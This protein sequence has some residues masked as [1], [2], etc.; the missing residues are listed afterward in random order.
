MPLPTPYA[1]WFEAVVG[2][3][4]PEEASATCDDCPM[5]AA[6]GFRP[7]T[8]CCTY[9]PPMANFQM[10]RA[11][12]AGGTAASAVRRRQPHAR[13]S[14]LG[15]LP[16][17]AEERLYE[18]H[19]EAFGRTQAVTCPFLKDGGCAVWAFRDVTCATWFCQHDAGAAGKA[20][21]DCA[22]DL[23]GLAEGLLAAHLSGW[24]LDEAAAEAERIS[25][26]EIR[27]LPGGD[28]LEV[29]ERALREAWT[30]SRAA[31]QSHG[32]DSEGLP[33]PGRDRGW[34]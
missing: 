27:A 8:K 25:W 33:A 18:D 5:C 24:P 19:H 11:L 3:P 21:W 17:R 9:I 23:L 2:A 16:T 26:T 30:L 32:R 12:R 4:P 28:A 29:H 1:G 31:S 20:M 10:A 14:P 6:R 22:A 15:L 13:R 7:S 34:R